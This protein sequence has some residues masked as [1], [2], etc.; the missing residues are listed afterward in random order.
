M[1]PRSNG[2]ALS[3]EQVSDAS[4][5]GTSTL[6]VKL[7][8]DQ[9]QPPIFQITVTSH[10]Q[11]SIM[12]PKKKA[13]SKKAAKSSNQSQ[14]LGERYTDNE[15]TDSLVQVSLAVQTP[16]RS[17]KVQIQSPVKTPQATGTLEDE[18]SEEGCGYSLKEVD[19]LIEN[20]D[21]EGELKCILGI[22]DLRELSHWG[23][24]LAVSAT[25]RLEAIDSKL[26]DLLENHLRQ[27]ED[28]RL[29][30]SKHV[31]DISVAD[32]FVKY[33]GSLKEALRAMAPKRTAEIDIDEL[34]KTAKKR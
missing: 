30:L 21:L 34:E 23:Y 29:R 14:P 20:F 12:P 19:Q 16:S 6:R 26:Q 3:R 2:H 28:E 15:A 10:L 22:R 17:L 27:C 24:H 9:Q 5:L 8:L 31:R 7:R 18:D 1:R 33:N 32:F 25:T 4:S 13:P 11:P